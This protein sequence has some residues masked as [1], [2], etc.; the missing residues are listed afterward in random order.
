MEE[1]TN[2]AEGLRQR[3]QETRSQLFRDVG[4]L[5][6]DARSVVD[7]RP[8]VK[9]HP[10]LAVGAAVGLGFF[11]APKRKGTL[12]LDA[13]TLA[14][15]ARDNRLVIQMQSEAKKTPGL[16]DTLLATVLAVAGRE[17]TTWFKKYLADSLRSAPPAESNPTDLR[18]PLPESE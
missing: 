8:K 7:W 15:L 10:W 14:N 9:R 1:P 6:H 17:A 12:H 13:K 16:F 3:M 2:P 4:S 11:L 18:Y 5:V